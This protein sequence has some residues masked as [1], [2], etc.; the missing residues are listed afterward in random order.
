[1]RFRQMASDGVFG[2]VVM[3]IG[4]RQPV[5]HIVK[6]WPRFKKRHH[7]PLGLAP[8]ANLTLRQIVR[9]ETAHR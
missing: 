2:F 9:Y 4:I 7:V 3:L 8:V 6:Y 1:M 5:R